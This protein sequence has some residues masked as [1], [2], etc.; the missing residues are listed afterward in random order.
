[1]RRSTSG[2]YDSPRGNLLAQLADDSMREGGNGG[3]VVVSRLG[4]PWINF[5]PPR[6]CVLVVGVGGRCTPK[7]LHIVQ[8]DVSHADQLRASFLGGP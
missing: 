5:C 2:P 6:L 3:W 7:H 4:F 1:M 8:G